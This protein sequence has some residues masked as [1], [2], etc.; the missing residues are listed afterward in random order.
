M[1]RDSAATYDL[2]VAAFGCHASDPNRPRTCA[3]F[4]LRGAADN[5]AIRMS[6]GDHSDVH[7]DVELYDNN[8]VEMA[9]ANGVDRDDP[10]P[11]PGRGER[12]GRIL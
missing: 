5:L 1:F 10:L 8:Y 7:S 6:R 4:L 3:G 12:S 9:V 2:A 11:A